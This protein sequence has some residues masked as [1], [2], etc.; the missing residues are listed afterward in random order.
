MQV[1][2]PMPKG[3]ETNRNRPA[4][5]SC[6][7]SVQCVCAH[8]AWVTTGGREERGVRGHNWAHCEA[9]GAQRRSGGRHPEPC[10][11]GRHHHPPPL[12][13]SRACAL[14]YAARALPLTPRPPSPRLVHTRTH[15]HL[16]RPTRRGAVSARSLISLPPMPCHAS[17]TTR[18]DQTM[19]ACMCLCGAVRCAR[20]SY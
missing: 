4:S 18:H 13:S 15:P 8:G 19:H 5:Y 11:I 14:S 1:L 12:P 7:G 10:R 16:R 6:S 9:R 17:P 2:A 3:N 20:A